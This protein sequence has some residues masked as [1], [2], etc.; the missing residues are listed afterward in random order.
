[1]ECKAAATELCVKQRV[2]SAAAAGRRIDWLLASLLLTIRNSD[3]D[4]SAGEAVRL[5]LDVALTGVGS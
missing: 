3:T 2:A 1:V 5:L 4:C